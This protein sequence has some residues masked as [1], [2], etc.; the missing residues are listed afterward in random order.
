[1]KLVDK[2]VTISKNPLSPKNRF[3]AKGL[4]IFVFFFFFPTLFFIVPNFVLDP[5]LNL[6]ELFSTMS[7]IF[8]GGTIIFMGVYFLLW[9]LK[10]QKEIGKGTPMPLMATQKLVIQAPYSFTRNP[11]ALGLI[12]FYIGISIVLGSISSLMIVLIF[13]SLI[14]VYIKFIEEKELAQRYGDDYLAYKEST[15]FLLPRRSSK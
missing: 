2:L 8:F 14:L 6:P 10:A 13:S 3:M 1:M 4:P 12:N 15:P 7:R 9:T 11:L 5:W